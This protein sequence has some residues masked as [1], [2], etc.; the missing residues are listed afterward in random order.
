MYKCMRFK[1][2]FC[3]VSIPSFK[4]RYRHE[5]FEL[6]LFCPRI[7]P[8]IQHYILLRWLNCHGVSLQ[9]PRLSGRW[10]TTRR[11][12]SMRN[13]LSIRNDVGHESVDQ[14]GS[15]DGKITEVK[16]LMHVLSIGLLLCFWK[17]LK[18]PYV[19]KT[20]LRCTY[21]TECLKGTVARDCRPLVFFNNRPH[22]GPWFTS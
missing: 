10:V 2:L 6:F 20:W 9:L 1:V 8:N 22:I 3:V 19:F 14:A 18:M 12:L 17:L 21:C 4:Y 5:A 15:F 13:L 11:R 16:N 7:H